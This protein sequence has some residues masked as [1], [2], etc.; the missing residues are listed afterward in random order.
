MVAAYH[1]YSYTTAQLREWRQAFLC[2][3]GK[4]GVNLLGIAQAA[5]RIGFK[6]LGVK[7]PLQ[8][9]LAEAPLPCIVHWGQNHFVVI[10][11]KP[12]GRAGLLV[13]DP[14]AGLLTYTLAE[15][16]SKWATAF[17]DSET[18]GIALLLDPT[19]Q[20][21]LNE[22][23]TDISLGSTKGIGLSYLFGYLWRYK[24]LVAQLGLGLLV[25]SMMQLILP[26]LTQSVV[27]I[28]VQTRNLHFITLVLMVQI[29][30]FVGRVSVDFIRSWVLLHI[31]T[32]VNLSILSDYLAKLLRLPIAYFDSKH[33]GDILQRI[34]DGS[35]RPP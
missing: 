1:G 23:D 16:E 20:N 29:M 22:S 28:G 24:N 13:A 6:T 19:L 21:R 34:G 27:D 17:A 8:K 35:G 12:R 25:G 26:F 32:R 11:P 7:V 9:L 10:A 2:E 30:L 3:I 18:V 5:E 31:S 33:T 4:D 14:A 15:F